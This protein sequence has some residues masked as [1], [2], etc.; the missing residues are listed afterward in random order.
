MKIHLDL[1]AALKRRFDDHHRE[2]KRQLKSVENKDAGTQK[3][4]PAR[5]RRVAELKRRILRAERHENTVLMVQRK[6]TFGKAL[7]PLCP[8][9]IIDQNKTSLLEESGSRYKCSNCDL[10]IEIES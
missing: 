3:G 8:I 6:G 7:C 2:L 5:A 10:V 4:N 1:P 9:C